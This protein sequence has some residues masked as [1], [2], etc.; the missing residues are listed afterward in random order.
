M[1]LF[2]DE[3]RDA[4]LETFTV[5]FHVLLEARVCKACLPTWTVTPLC[6]EDQI[7]VLGSTWGRVRMRVRCLRPLPQARKLRDQ[8]I[9]INQH[10]E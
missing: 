2:T 4:V 3:R 1:N 7:Q 6:R 9:L 10:K 8:T 5:S